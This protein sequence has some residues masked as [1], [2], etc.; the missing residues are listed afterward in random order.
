MIGVVQLALFKNSKIDQEKTAQNVKAFFTDDFKHYLNLA[1]KHLSDISSPTL[2][3]NN[4]GG[5]DGLNHQDE[6][7]VVNLDAQN[8]V[9][10]VNHTLSSCSYPSN[11]VLY[12]Y[13]IKK[14]SNDSIAQRLGYQSTRFIEIKKE[15]LVEFAERFDFWRQEDKTS[16]E[17]LR[18]FEHEE[19]I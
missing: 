12:L 9:K 15:A 1:N 16:M 7:M 13:F 10:A 8:C 5:H 3:P 2:D 4:M 18:V 19:M 17:D 14:I 6:R 11:T